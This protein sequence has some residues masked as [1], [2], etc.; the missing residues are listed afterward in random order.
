MCDSKQ[1]ECID[2]ST[3]FLPEKPV[4]VIKKDGSKEA[5]NVQKVISAVGKSAYRALTEFTEEEKQQIC[6]YVVD[7]VNELNKQEIPIPVM[8]NMV[9]SALELVKPVVAKSYREYRDYKKDIVHMLDE[10]Y[11]KAQVIT[12]I[13]YAIAVVMILWL[14]VQWIL[15]TPAKK[16]ELKGKMWSMAIGIVLLVGGVSI[17]NFVWGAAESA[18]TL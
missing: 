14:G 7:K 4:C 5:F 17:L 3:M 11:K 8:H 15:A 2:Y 13:G 1:M 16:A 18:N 9:E 10:V 12:Y 6:Q